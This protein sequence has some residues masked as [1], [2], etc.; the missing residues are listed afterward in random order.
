M[1]WY[2]DKG[3]FEMENKV[4]WLEKHIMFPLSEPDHAIYLVACYSPGNSYPDRRWR[5]W[6]RWM[7]P[8]AWPCKAESAEW[9]PMSSSVNHICEKPLRHPRSRTGRSKPR[10][11]ELRTGATTASWNWQKTMESRSAWAL[12]CPAW[13]HSSGNFTSLMSERHT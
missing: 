10:K 3:P 7:P 12:C 6:G 9:G 4:N 13:A 2:F 5:V 11:G 1:A 8:K